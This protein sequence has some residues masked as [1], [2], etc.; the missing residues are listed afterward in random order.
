MS[1]IKRLSVSACIGE[2]PV[3]QIVAEAMQ[4]LLENPPEVIV[5]AERYRGNSPVR[6]TN[7]TNRVMMMLDHRLNKMIQP[8]EERN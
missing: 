4:V 1:K 6:E 5:T 8:E 3:R 7:G 2:K